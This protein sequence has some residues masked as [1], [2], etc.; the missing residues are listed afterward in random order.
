MRK[1]F[2]S[3]FAFVFAFSCNNVFA[4]NGVIGRW[5]VGE[6]ISPIDDSVDALAFTMTE[7]GKKGLAVKCENGELF[8]VLSPNMDLNYSDRTADL[9]IRWG[10]EQAYNQSWKIFSEKLLALP[11]DEHKDFVKNLIKNEKLAMQID[12]KKDNAIAVFEL[13]ETEK[14]LEKIFEYCPTLKN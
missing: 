7:D 6:T 5:I 1:I 11:N 14:A 2:F 12:T 10:K 9:R 8:I 4:E 3:V 13:E